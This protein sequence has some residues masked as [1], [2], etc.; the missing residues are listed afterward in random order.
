MIMKAKIFNLFLLTM[1]CQP[2]FAMKHTIAQ[3]SS[4]SA[5][6]P[7]KRQKTASLTPAIIAEVPTLKVLAA[8]AA[9][10][11]RNIDKEI[12]SLPGD[13]QPQLLEQLIQKNRFCFYPM[14]K[15][16]P[17]A[18]FD[19]GVGCTEL[20][21][22]GK[23]VVLYTGGKVLLYDL[24]AWPITPIILQEKPPHY[25][26]C[27]QFSQN[28]SFLVIDFLDGGVCVW[29]VRTDAIECRKLEK[30]PKGRVLNAAV[31]NDGK[32]LVL[33]HLDNEEHESFVYY[34]LSSNGVK[35]HCLDDPNEINEHYHPLSDVLMMSGSGKYI[36]MKYIKDNLY[37]KI[38]LWDLD[39]LKIVKSV[40]SEI[41]DEHELTASLSENGR[42]AMVLSANDVEQTRFFSLSIFDL[43]EPSIRHFSATS[44][45]IPLVNGY[46]YKDMAIA[47]NSLIAAVDKNG[48][49]AGFLHHDIEHEPHWFLISMSHDGITNEYA[50]RPPPC[51]EIDTSQRSCLALD[52]TGRH[53]FFTGQ[54]MLYV[55]DLQNRQVVALAQP[56]QPGPKKL[57][58]SPDGRHLLAK[59]NGRICYWDLLAEAY[60]LN[61]S[62]ARKIIVHFEDVWSL[63]FDKTE[64]SG[65]PN[66]S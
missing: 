19:G 38:I 26:G 49:S 9:L 30:Q 61:F 22:D 25:L 39:E 10:L 6:Q 27:M 7:L 5:E 3:E 66:R 28:G 50:L 13:L 1:A 11:R 12:T 58:V 63:L 2:C 64:M 57:V 60:K 18:L 15:K 65:M 43:A 41:E 51:I 40:I 32:R 17:H 4:V 59:T 20:C 36:L 47:N 35:S 21:P 8:A 62:Q 37:S 14:I 34:Q 46:A 54:D 29:D 56:A 53:A 16:D 55:A 33:H 24:S 52:A 23:R 45:A 31:S 44:D 42:Y 48:F